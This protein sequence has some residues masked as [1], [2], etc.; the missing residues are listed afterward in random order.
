MSESWQQQFRRALLSYLIEQ[1]RVPP[2][3]YLRPWEEDDPSATR[4]MHEHFDRTLTACTPDTAKSSWKDDLW[5]VWGGTFSEDTIE[6][7]IL[8]TVSCTCGEIVQVKVRYTGSYADL[9]TGITREN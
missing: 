2:Q 5:T 8:A 9:I 4:R 1:G 6:P 7:C 3:H